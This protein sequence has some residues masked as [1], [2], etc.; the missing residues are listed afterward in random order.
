MDANKSLKKQVSKFNETHANNMLETLD[1]QMEVH[2]DIFVLVAK[3]TN[4][5]TN[6]LKEIIDDLI[7]RHQQSIVT[8]VSVNEDKITA[9]AKVSKSCLDKLHEPKE[10][11]QII[12]GKGGGRRDMAQGGATISS[13][14]DAK[15]DK[16]LSLIKESLVVTQ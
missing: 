7:N 9:V 4:V 10:L 14:L 6:K 8:L 12:C 5:D 13:D 15:L 16:V 1:Q 2:D 3:V 11:I